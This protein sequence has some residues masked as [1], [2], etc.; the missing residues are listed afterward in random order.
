MKFVLMTI[1][2]FSIFHAVLSLKCYKCNDP[3]FN[4]NDWQCLQPTQV[5]CQNGQVC[6]KATGNVNG[7]TIVSK[8]CYPEKVCKSF[9][10]PFAVNENGTYLIANCC[11]NNLCNGS[12][13]RFQNK[14]LYFTLVLTAIFKLFS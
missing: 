7:K 10:E 8:T 12:E 3:E 1:G 5:E 9:D 2:L 13:S 4:F 6:G 11:K 14:L